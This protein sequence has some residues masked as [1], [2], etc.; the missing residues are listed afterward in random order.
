MPDSLVSC[1]T[2]EASIGENISQE[3]G[4]VFLNMQS[5]GGGL[6]C[7][8]IN[9]FAPE[10]VSLPRYYQRSSNLTR[11]LVEVLKDRDTSTG[12]DWEYSSKSVYSISVPDAESRD[13]LNLAPGGESAEF[14]L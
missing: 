8:Q 9:W 2:F 5:V 13:Q 6:G 11:K 3:N 7:G 14:W 1:F 12:Y 4:R 10:I